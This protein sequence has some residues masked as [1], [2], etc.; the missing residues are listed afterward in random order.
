MGASGYFGNVF[1][2]LRFKNEL[3]AASPTFIIHSS[4]GITENLEIWETAASC[5]KNDGYERFEQCIVD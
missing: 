5:K 3:Q 1:V 2:V 4:L